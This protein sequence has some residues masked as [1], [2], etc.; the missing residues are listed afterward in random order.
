MATVIKVANKNINLDRLAEELEAAGI[1]M[2]GLLLAGFHRVGLN[3]YEPN[4]A[5]QVIA[6]RSSPDGN[7]EDEADPGE[8]RFRFPADLSA[9]QV[10]TLDPVLAAHD[11]AVL[12]VGQRNIK[13]DEDAVPL[14]ATAYQDWDSLTPPQ[15]DDA[16]RLVVRSVARAL[17]GSIDL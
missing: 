12:S 15:K 16:L 11:P 13:A 6:R 8:L 3:T 10:T 2:E 7:I 9:D 4:A 1:P 5:R 17:D 14:L